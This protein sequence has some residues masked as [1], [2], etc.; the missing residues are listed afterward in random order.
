MR[1]ILEPLQKHQQLTQ[2]LQE[3]IVSGSWGEGDRFPSQNALA[4]Q[5]GVSVPTVREALSA[6]RHQG[7]IVQI[8]GKGT[9][10]ARKPARPESAYTVGLV[11]CDLSRAY[12][13]ELASAIDDACRAR[14]LHLHIGLHDRSVEDKRAS[15]RRMRRENLDGILLGP[16]SD[17]DELRFILNGEPVPDNLVIIGNVGPVQAHSVTVDLADGV[18]SAVEHLY[19][20]GHRRIAMITPD[21]LR[22]RWTRLYGFEQAA[23]R[24][25]IEPV[26][27]AAEDGDVL[28][29]AEGGK[30]VIAALF[31]SDAPEATRPTALLMH[32]D[33]S[34]LGAIRQLLMM[35]LRVPEDVSVVGFDDVEMAQYGAVALT[36]LGDT[37]RP[38]A[39]EA[40][41]LLADVLAARGRPVDRF[42]QKVLSPRLIIRQSTCPPD[43]GR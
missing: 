1:P 10:V 37:I 33:M 26:G 19:G 12:Y 14:N 13:G 34:A 5:Y 6:L 29:F 25:G 20:L 11:T 28:N 39:E 18:I 32:N 41:S 35:G 22:L 40:V 7:L 43:G 38:L 23:R 21:E 24:F 8:Q 17:E 16:I 30:N 2:I 31:G 27:Y 4:R 3:A 42:H 15:Y 9:F 36:T